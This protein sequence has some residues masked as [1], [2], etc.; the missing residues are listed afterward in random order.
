MMLQ[1]RFQTF[2]FLQ[3][4]HFAVDVLLVPLLCVSVTQ[5]C[6][7]SCGGGGQLCINGAQHADCSG[8]F[9]YCAQQNETCNGRCGKEN[10]VLSVALNGTTTCETCNYKD[11]NT[12]SACLSCAEEDDYYWYGYR[13]WCTEELKCIHTTSQ[14]AGKCLHHEYPIRDRNDSCTSCPEGKLWCDQ[15]QKCITIFD[16][17]CNQECAGSENSVYCPETDK[18]INGSEPCGTSCDIN[19]FDII[20]C[21]NMNLCLDE[22]SFIKEVYTLGNNCTS[23]CPHTQIWCEKDKKCYDPLNEPCNQKCVGQESNIYCPETN[24]CINSSQPCGTSCDIHSYSEAFPTEKI[25]CENMNLCLDE[26]RFINEVYTVGTNCT[27]RC[28]QTQIWCE[29][30]KKCYDPLN[31]PCNQGCR[32]TNLGYCPKTNSCLDYKESC[33]G[34]CMRDAY[35]ELTYCSLEDKCKF[36]YDTIQPC[37]AKCEDFYIFCDLTHECLW[38]NDFKYETINCS[39]RC[40]INR[41]WCEEE[42]KCYDPL[43]EPCNQDCKNYHPHNIYCNETNTCIQYDSVCGEK[44][45]SDNYIYSSSSKT[46][47][48]DF[49]MLYDEEY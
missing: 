29:E 40:P 30:D 49:S 32:K 23:R 7:I 26:Q 34:S 35:V 5:S 46:C 24:K 28:S 43:I 17:S 21:E 33:D 6:S 39:R 1:K 47:S 14:C 22:Q 36:K 12:Q 44:C 20:F 38:V 10:P 9:W 13:M 8:G 25:L 41:A 48:Y 18:C 15:K 42:T 37:N 11:D 31:E 27:N 16:E 4:W 45:V 19:Y 2:Q 3:S